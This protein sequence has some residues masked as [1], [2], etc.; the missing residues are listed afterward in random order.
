[1]KTRTGIVH[2]ASFAHGILFDPE[3]L[4]SNAQ[5]VRFDI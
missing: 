2:K 3:F 5:L 1:M 4:A